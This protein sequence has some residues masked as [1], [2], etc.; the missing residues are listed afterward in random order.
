MMN[1]RE[2]ASF[3]FIIIF[4]FNC[5]MIAACVF[6]G[7]LSIQFDTTVQGIIRNG[8]CVCA[9]CMCMVHVVYA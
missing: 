9:G 7:N 5:M 2:Y 3:S 1:V 6:S 8:M 4:I